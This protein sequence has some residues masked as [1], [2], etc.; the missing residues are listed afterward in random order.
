MD[1]SN[2]SN[3]EECKI[4]EEYNR[5]LN[6][7]DQW[8]EHPLPKKRRVAGRRFD[9]MLSLRLTTE[10]MH[11]LYEAAKARDMTISQFIRESALKAAGLPYVRITGLPQVTSYTA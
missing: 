2:C 5:L 9:N 4:F 1:H 8:W 3:P 6:D 10:Q 11:T 7:P